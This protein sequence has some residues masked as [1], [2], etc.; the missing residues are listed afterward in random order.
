MGAV[1]AFFSSAVLLL[2]QAEAVKQTS[3][4]TGND[5]KKFI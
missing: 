5:F 1:A 4:T 2:L 3:A